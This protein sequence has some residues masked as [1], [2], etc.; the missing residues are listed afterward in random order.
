MHHLRTILGST[1]NDT[2][3]KVKQGLLREC[4]GLAAKLVLSLY[5]LGLPLC[6]WLLSGSLHLH[7]HLPSPSLDT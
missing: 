4:E 3:S 1:G 5:L 7:C 2:E 6:T